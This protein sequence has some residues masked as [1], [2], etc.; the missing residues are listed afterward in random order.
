MMPIIILYSLSREIVLIKSWGMCCWTN[1]KPKSVKPT[2][3]VFPF[4]IRQRKCCPSRAFVYFS[5]CVAHHSCPILSTFTNEGI[6]A[7]LSK[8]CTFACIVPIRILLSC[9]FF[10]F[11]KPRNGMILVDAFFKFTIRITS[12]LYSFVIC[13]SKSSDKSC[14]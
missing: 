9:T 2:A 4:P 12:F 11:Q 10:L 1:N 14:L 6:E 13:L 8:T 5:K 3:D 7:W